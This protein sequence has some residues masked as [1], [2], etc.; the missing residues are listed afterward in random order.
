MFKAVKF[1]K[2]RLREGLDEVRSADL[3]RLNEDFLTATVFSRLLYMPSDVLSGLLLLNNASRLGKLEGSMFWP[4]WWATAGNGSAIRVEP[5]L[6]VEFEGLDLIVEAKL[7]DDPGSQAPDQWAR[8]WAA[9]HQQNRTGPGKQPLLLGVGGLGATDNVTKSAASE[10]AEAANHLLLADFPGVPAI[11]AAGISWQGLFD[12]L[13][14][15]GLGDQISSQ[16]LQDLLEILGYFGLRQYR[17][18]GDLSGTM[19]RSMTHTIG[20]GLDI[21]GRW[22][23]AWHAPD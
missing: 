22:S 12:R 20:D 15:V 23:A 3:F 13:T 11:Q 16:L 4:T 19:R 5:D 6:Y 17:Y 1:G 9:W 2:V 21:L 14:S 7:S 8:E 18:L 10:I